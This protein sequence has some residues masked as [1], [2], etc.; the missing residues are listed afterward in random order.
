MNLTA[1]QRSDEYRLRWLHQHLHG[2][3]VQIGW[4]DDALQQMH[5]CRVTM[6]D[7]LYVL[8]A[9]TVVSSQYNGNCFALCGED[10]DGRR[11]TVVV[12]PPSSKDRV[13]IVKV[14]MDAP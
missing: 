1:D 6:Q 13:R 2:D 10:L 11:L 5:E 12:A 14:W 3:C 4:N 9:A 7:V 8:R